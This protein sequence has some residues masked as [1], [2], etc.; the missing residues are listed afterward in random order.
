MG[1]ERR[2]CI[3]RLYWM[4][5]QKWEEPLNKA[6]PF[7]IAKRVVWEAYKRVKANQGVAGVDGES[8]A[9][10]ERDLTN[11]LY[12]LW[13]RMS[14]GSYFPP[15]VRTVEIPKSDG[16]KRAL[17]IPTV[18]DRVAQ[19]VVKMYLEPLVEPHF[20]QDSYGYRPGR[21]AIQAVG[22]ARQRCWRID[23]VLDLDIK[24]F[25]DNLDHA[26]LMRAV[27]KHTD[28][29]WIILYI[30]RWLTAP[31]QL[32][33]GTLV[34]REQGT[35]QGGV[36]SPLLANLFLHYAFDVW[37]QR[38]YP[39]IPF[40]RYADDIIVH[41]KSE[42]QALWLKTAVVRRLAQCKLELHP[43]K[44]KIVYC[45]DVDRTDDYPKESFDFLGFE[46]RPR[47]AKSR[48]GSYFVSFLP[49]VSKKGARSIRSVIRGWRLHRLSDKGLL[50]LSRMFNPIIRGWI[51]YYGSFYK[52]ALYPLFDQLDGSLKKWAMRK[53]K[54]LRG[55]Q[56]RAA[57]WLSR[58]RSQQPSLFSHWQLASHLVAGR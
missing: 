38:H 18:T 21:S 4:V 51:N 28:C 2:G 47:G 46:F 32:P 22:V 33:D 49:A 43:E 29:R 39:S 10:F 40:E 56:R 54:R 11:N 55:R 8:I 42:R 41:C 48:L 35:P 9:E 3:D 26:L 17:G 6:R 53:Y 24:G 20:H 30:A 19:M 23:W 44:T 52:S 1:M 13:N 15:P 7:S 16:G 50:D 57:Y 58:I 25:F 34:A 27:R 45:K 37:M 31:A 12:K 36:I 14:S 5:N